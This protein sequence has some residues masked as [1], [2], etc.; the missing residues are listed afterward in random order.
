MRDS[1]WYLGSMTSTEMA[2]LTKPSLRVGY[3]VSSPCMIHVFS[4][5]SR[6]ISL[7]SR[8]NS[9]QS[10]QERTRTPDKREGLRPYAGAVV[11]AEE[12]V[13][14]E[15]DHLRVRKG[16][17]LVEIHGRLLFRMRS[18]CGVVLTQVRM[19]PHLLLTPP[20]PS[21]FMSRQAPRL[22]GRPRARQP[23]NEFR[24]RHP[25]QGYDDIRQ[26]TRR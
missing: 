4:F 18:S 15:E 25:R 19:H 11:D 12:R 1:P 13:P 24:L 10:R 23:R 2:F 7:W 20:P 22:R 21:V 26:P 16:G 8:L 6:V 9:A 14:D 5:V 17:L 3:A